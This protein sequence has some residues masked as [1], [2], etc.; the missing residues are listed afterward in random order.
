[1]QF[2]P[3]IFSTEQLLKLTVSTQQLFSNHPSTT[4]NNYRNIS[5]VLYF[6]CCRDYSKNPYELEATKHIAAQSWIDHNKNIFNQV[7]DLFKKFIPE[8]FHRYSSIPLPKRHFGAFATV[9]VNKLS[10]NGIALHQDVKDYKNGY[11][12][13][14]PFGKFDGGNFLLKDINVTVPLQAADIMC[15]QSTKRH[16]VKPFEGFRFSLV[17]FSHHN[18]FYYNGNQMF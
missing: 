3:G 9:A 12:W 8:L 11:C 16:Q 1:M 7:N 13:I 14:V 5:N 2:H 18:L 15:L 6:G 17:F 4:N 10:N